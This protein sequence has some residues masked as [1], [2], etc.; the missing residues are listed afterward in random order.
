MRARRI[1]LI[2][3]APALGAGAALWVVARRAAVP[4]PPTEA[5]QNSAGP[6]RTN[7][8]RSPVRASAR[9]TSTAADPTPTPASAVR[10]RGEF[11]TPLGAS[12]RCVLVRAKESKTPIAGA[13]VEIEHDDGTVA[14][15]ETRADGTASFD[16]N[17]CAGPSFRVSA[18]GRARTGWF[19]DGARRE[20]SSL[21][22]PV[23]LDRGVEL[24]G[25]VVDVEHG[26]PVPDVAVR[27]SRQAWFGSGLD[28]EDRTTSDADG[29]F[30]F[31]AVAAPATIYAPGLAL[32]L[33]FGRTG[34]VDAEAEPAVLSAGS[35]AV[36]VTVRLERDASVRGTVLSPDGA[37]AADAAV[38]VERRADPRF[39]IA[40]PSARADARGEFAVRGLAAGSHVLV[41][42]GRDDCA[43]S[44]T[45]EVLVGA[46]TPLTL[47]LRRR[48]AC[49]LRVTGPD[50]NDLPQCHVAVFDPEHSTSVQ[51]SG[52][53]SPLALTVEPVRVGVKADADG[54]ASDFRWFDA[55]SEGDVLVLALDRAGA[56][57]GVVLDDGGCAVEGA[58][59]DVGPSEYAGCEASTHLVRSA[60][61]G[62]DGSFRV[63]PLGARDLTLDVQSG[64]HVRVVRR[65]RVA[66][67]PI[68][69]VLVR[70]GSFE[71]T[72]VP[73]K[74][75]KPPE[76]CGVYF[77]GDAPSVALPAWEGGDGRARVQGAIARGR[78][79]VNDVPPGRWEFEVRMSDF[80]DPGLV[81]DVASG[82][83]TTLP[84]VR[85]DAG[86]AVE[87]RVIDAGGRPVAHVQVA[88]SL[89]GGVGYTDEEG[90]FRIGQLRPGRQILFTSGPGVAARLETV[91][92]VETKPVTLRLAPRRHVRIHLRDERGGPVLE[93]AFTL[94]AE[95]VDW[96]PW[97]RPDGRGDLDCELAPA[98]YDFSTAD[99]PRGEW[100]RVDSFEIAPPPTGDDPGV[101][102]TVR[103]AV[104]PAEHSGK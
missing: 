11:Y 67:S 75:M 79:R 15:Y 49:K 93:G 28:F 41:R 78:L 20:R 56:L 24:R 57:E 8:T 44:E 22:I 80:V 52:G 4:A 54:F 43:A 36:D 103:V 70:T 60:R 47:C 18:P 35:P 40:A 21:R 59:V 104:P 90:R 89:G 33:H 94:S 17:P 30:A 23:D 39:D 86:L 66:E 1:G 85:L 42:A 2:I 32:R 84:D 63:E 82:R 45:V 102:V 87:G 50:G 88:S 98:R 6:P 61:S 34:Y 53:P 26:S 37:P 29:R 19:R 55:P 100:R 9:A 58:S 72:L 31:P 64:G 65:V 16:E 99:G 38:F 69:V 74:G 51:S 12:T 83:T 48:V 101:E 14:T 7:S 92:G 77:R 62:P 76:T 10:P 46:E 91:V 71:A 25:R 96:M 81:V 13:V 68:R 97:F 5:V 73:P 95:G 27:A 3:A